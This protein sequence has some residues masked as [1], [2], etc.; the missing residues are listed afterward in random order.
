[1]SI[2]C[3]FFHG[4]SSF[5]QSVCSF[6]AQFF[7]SELASSERRQYLQSSSDGR[8]RLQRRLSSAQNRCFTQ[9]SPAVMLEKMKALCGD[10]NNIS[11][12]Y[13][14]L[15]VLL[16]IDRNSGSVL[17]RFLLCERILTLQVKSALLVAYNSLSAEQSM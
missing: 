7:G 14:V 2:H 16:Q 9:H 15:S 8:L 1:M 10:D 4:F 5:S 11:D 12:N 6:C 17:V 3:V 13:I